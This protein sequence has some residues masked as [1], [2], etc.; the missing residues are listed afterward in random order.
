MYKLE[1]LEDVWNVWLVNAMKGKTIFYT[2]V[3]IFL[4]KARTLYYTLER[5][6][7]FI[8]HNLNQYFDK[9]KYDRH[10][11]HWLNR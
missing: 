1:T 5:F 10:C 4:Y 3:H 2:Y 6:H 7:Q 9:D 11:Y 8:L